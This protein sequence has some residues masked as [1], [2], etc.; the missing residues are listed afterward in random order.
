MGN[1]LETTDRQSKRRGFF[2]R[3]AG[4]DFWMNVLWS[5]RLN[6]DEHLWPFAGNTLTLLLRT[7]RLM[8]PTRRVSEALLR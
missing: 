7:A 6:K 5:W 2:D 8:L 1:Q 3:P 4:V